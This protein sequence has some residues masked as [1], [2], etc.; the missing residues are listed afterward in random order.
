MESG[1]VNLNCVQHG[2]K[3]DPGV[4]EK[5]TKMYEKQ[6]KQ[7]NVEESPTRRAKKHQKCF[8]TREEAL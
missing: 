4:K 7:K 1:T 5:I 3:H 2:K 6:A 8:S